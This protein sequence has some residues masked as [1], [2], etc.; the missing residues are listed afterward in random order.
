M[1]ELVFWSA[2]QLAAAIRDRTV[3]SIEVIEAHL[4]QIAQHNPAINAIATLQADQA[5]E[6]AHQA[7]AALAQGEWWGPLHGV[8]VTCKDN[9]ETAGLRT[10]CGYQPLSEYVPQQDATVVARLRNAG[11]ILLGKTNMPPLGT[12][13]QTNNALFGRTNNPW[14]LA[15]TCGGSTGGGAAAIAAGLSPLETGSDSGGSIRVPAHFCGVFG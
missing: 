15:Y 13:L 14:H 12:G 4:Q 3:S 5:R 10:T 7:D 8:P 11:A 6:Q 2:S 1:S 9:F